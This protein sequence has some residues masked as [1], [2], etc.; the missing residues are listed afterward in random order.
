M[1]KID[2]TVLSASTGGFDKIVRITPMRDVA[3]LHGAVADRSTLARNGANRLW[4]RLREEASFT[5]LE[6]LSGNQ[7]KQVV[8]ARLPIDC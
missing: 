3:R 8:R 5:A 1:T 4:K 7:A 2:T 6:V